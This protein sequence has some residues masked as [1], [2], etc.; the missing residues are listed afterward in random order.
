MS[1]NEHNFFFLFL[2]VFVTISLTSVCLF[3]KYHVHQ[4]DV[5]RELPAKHWV[6]R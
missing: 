2:C 4:L 1:D 5:C 6:C 3:Y